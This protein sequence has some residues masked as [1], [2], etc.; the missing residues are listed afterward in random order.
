M[1]LCGS[2]QIRLEC[3]PFIEHKTLTLPAGCTLRFLEVLE[4]AAFEL[5]AVLQ[6]HVLHHQGGLFAA[7]AACA[8]AHHGFIA[9]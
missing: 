6:A 7:Y 8:V 2:A 5:I 4:D 9:Q 3:H 1:R